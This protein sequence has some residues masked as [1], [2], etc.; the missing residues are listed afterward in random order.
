MIEFLIYSITINILDKN[1]EEKMLKYVFFLMLIFLSVSCTTQNLLIGKGSLYKK[2]NRD[3]F[4]KQSQYKVDID[5]NAESVSVS[6]LDDPPHTLQCN[7]PISMTDQVLFVKIQEKKNL[8]IDR[9][10]ILGKEYLFESSFNRNQLILMFHLPIIYL[11][12]GYVPFNLHVGLLNTQT[13]EIS[14][15]KKTIVFNWSPKIK[16]VDKQTGFAYSANLIDRRH[17]PLEKSVYISEIKNE[18]QKT[19]K[20]RFNQKYLQKILFF[21]QDESN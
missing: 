11:A 20:L 4:L 5:K 12:E 10:L 15:M 1:N 8:N 13:N 18:L 19:N 14:V 17:E 6:L 2:I 21:I 3:Q 9:H 7:V 16:P